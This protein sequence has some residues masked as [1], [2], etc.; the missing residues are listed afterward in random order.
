MIQRAGS[1]GVPSPKVSSM[2][3]MPT[4]QYYFEV[5]LGTYIESWVKQKAR[6]KLSTHACGYF[7]YNQDPTLMIIKHNFMV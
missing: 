5:R 4:W 1:H 2:T 3:W 7:A 6:P